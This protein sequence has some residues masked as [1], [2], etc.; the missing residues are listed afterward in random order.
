MR[1]ALLALASLAAVATLFAQA[2][3]PAPDKPREQ[4]PALCTVSGRVVTAADGTPLKSARVILGQEHEGRHSR[5]YAARSDS[6][7]HF[8]LKGILP[9]RYKFFALHNGYVDQEYK[10]NGVNGG[11]VLALHP[12]EQLADVLFRLTMAAVITGRVTGEDGAAL[13]HLRLLAM[14]KPTDEEVIEEDLSESQRQE[15][16]WASAAYTDDRGQ[17][18]IFGLKPGEYY[19]QATDSLEPDHDFIAGREALAQEF[20]GYSSGL[21]RFDRLS[22]LRIG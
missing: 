17:Y 19:V 6:D 14:Y 22:A 9:G 12:G 7:G 18:R 15:P 2:P 8:T 13:V 10:A 4:T 5:N 3:A 16:S 11:A 21:G 20:L 1:Q